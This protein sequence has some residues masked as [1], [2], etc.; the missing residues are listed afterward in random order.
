MVIA[1]KGVSGMVPPG[2]GSVNEAADFDENKRLSRVQ[3]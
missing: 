3:Q 1:P 2:Y